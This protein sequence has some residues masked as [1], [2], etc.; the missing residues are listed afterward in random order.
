MLSYA[1]PLYLLKNALP[2][3][4][5]MNQ[6]QG[7]RQS[8]INALLIHSSLLCSACRSRNYCSHRCHVVASNRLIL[9][10]SS[11]SSSA[12]L[13]LLLFDLLLSNLFPLFLLLL[14]S[15][16]QQQQLLLLLLLEQ[17]RQVHPEY[18][19]SSSR[20]IASFSKLSIIST[21]FR[22][23]CQVRSLIFFWRLK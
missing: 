14:L 9:G 7:R 8:Y 12:L 10:R 3:A 22:S 4:I 2:G 23:P 19:S 11:G 1:L 17:P 16:L 15:L 18:M 20:A 5:R 21:A 6:L 13:L